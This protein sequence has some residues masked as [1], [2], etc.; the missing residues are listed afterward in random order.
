[1]VIPA[2]SAPPKTS[3]PS[4]TS[5]PLW[6]KIHHLAAQSL[7]APKS[8]DPGDPY[9]RTTSQPIPARS[10]DISSPTTCIVDLRVAPLSG[11]DKHI[12]R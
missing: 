3:G 8:R 1:M 12:R 4:G 11:P 5:N 6:L 10:T 2:T 7:E 9:T